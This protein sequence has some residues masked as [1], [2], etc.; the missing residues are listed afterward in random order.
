MVLL[1]PLTTQ[2]FSSQAP[3]SVGMLEKEVLRSSSSQVSG[4]S[5]VYAVVACITYDFYAIAL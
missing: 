4:D 2:I 1:Q 3:S 5:L